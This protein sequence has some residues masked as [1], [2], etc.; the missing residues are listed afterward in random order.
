MCQWYVFYIGNFVDEHIH[1]DSVYLMW[2]TRKIFATWTLSKRNNDNNHHYRR[3]HHH[4]HCLRQ[5][6]LR[7]FFFFSAIFTPFTPLQSEQRECISLWTATFR[8]IV[9]VPMM[10]VCTIFICKLHSHCCIWRAT[11]L[12][13]E[14]FF[15]SFL[16]GIPIVR[17]F[18][19]FSRSIFISL[20]IR[21]N[22][23]AIGSN[24]VTTHSLFTIHIAHT[25]RTFRVK[26]QYDFRRVFTYNSQEHRAYSV[27][28]HTRHN[29]THWL[30]SIR[31][32]LSASK[33]FTYTW[34]PLKL[35]LC[36][37]SSSRSFVHF[38][39]EVVTRCCTRRLN[40]REKNTRKKNTLE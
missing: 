8:Q 16:F 25:R 38:A 19:F 30:A 2:L 33:P 35:I 12:Q 28:I 7:S 39:D 29:Y 31:S 18:A 5:H 11:E 27:Y 20:A 3:H 26:S 17:S 15:C 24:D 14:W 10:I 4:H 13:T 6:F 9:H 34:R 21:T 40:K 32:L 36:A 22:Q 23:P 37:L 1:F